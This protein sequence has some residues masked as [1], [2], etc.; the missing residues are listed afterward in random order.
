MFN[1]ISELKNRSLNLTSLLLV[2]DSVVVGACSAVGFNIIL[3]LSTSAEVSCFYPIPSIN[4]S[5][6]F[7]TSTLQFSVFC[8]L[9]P[10]TGWFADIMIGRKKAIH[11]SLW[12]CWLGVLLQIISYCIQFGLCGLLVNLAKYGISSVALL[13]II[14]GSAGLFTN[15]PPYGLDQLYDK[16]NSHSRAFIHWAVW[17]IYV[18]YSTGYI[19]FVSKSIYEPNLLI[20]TSIVIFVESSFALC[21]HSK[22]DHKFEF[23]E[24]LV[25]NPYKMVY[26]V[27]KY[28]WQNKYPENRSALTYWENKIPNRI[29]LGKY[30]YGGPFKEEDVEDTKTFWRIMI[31]ILSTFGFF[32]AY[33]HTVLGVLSYTNSFKDSTN[34][35]N[36][37]GSYALWSLFNELI[38]IIVP[39]LELG[40]IPLFPKIEYFLTNPLRG[41]GITYV[42]LSISLIIMLTIDTIGHFITQYE[43]GCSLSSNASQVDMSYLY[44]MIPFAFSGIVGGLHTIF[45]LEFICSQ[46]PVNMNGML[47][48][49][50]WLVRAIY[51]NIG[52]YLLMPFTNFDLN[53]PG[54]LDCSFWSLSTQ[55]GKYSTFRYQVHKCL[56]HELYISMKCKAGITSN[57]LYTNALVTKWY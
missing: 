40:I 42:L 43:V 4:S 5:H 23:S 29:N 56:W 32:I 54:R 12:S 53:G 38:V 50:F 44:Y 7:I 35:L 15:I 2:I 10:L 14:I 36:G 18:G 1:F 25:K 24:T 21:L 52:A 30:K 45:I 57:T 27:L 9:Y 46:A 8:I 13:L 51:I 20:T 41:F 49:M 22:F 33:Y 19:A 37:Y 17:G 28:A 26:L 47:T 6:M 31:V 3:S 34:S 16:S 39:I 11:L 55:L 48:G